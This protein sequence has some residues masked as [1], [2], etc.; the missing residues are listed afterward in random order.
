MVPNPLIFASYFLGGEIETC[1]R[2]TGTHSSW[3]RPVH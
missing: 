1:L 3:S 2:R